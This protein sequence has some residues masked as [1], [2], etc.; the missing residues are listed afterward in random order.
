MRGDPWLRPRL[1]LCRLDAH[2]ATLQRPP[3]LELHFAISEGEKGVI[4]TET[5]IRTRVKLRAP[6]THEDVPRFRRLAA[7]Q[8]NAEAL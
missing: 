5:H 8:L 1:G 2:V 3:H 4:P 7:E 6:L